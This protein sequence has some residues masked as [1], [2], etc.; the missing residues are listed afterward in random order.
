MNGS[1]CYNCYSTVYSSESSSDSSSND[2]SFNNDNSA[3][4]DFQ[5]FDP[6]MDN[7]SVPVS[8]FYLNYNVSLVS[9]NIVGHQTINRDIKR[10]NNIPQF[11]FKKNPIVSSEQINKALDSYFGAGDKPV[12]VKANPQSAFLASLNMPIYQGPVDFFGPINEQ[13]GQNF[14][15]NILKPW[16]LQNTVAVPIINNCVLESPG[17]NPSYKTRGSRFSFLD[18]KGIQYNV[19]DNP[20]TWDM[21]LNASK[22]PSVV[23]LDSRDVRRAR[24]VR[25]FNKPYRGFANIYPES[26]EETDGYELALPSSTLSNLDE[27]DMPE[28]FPVYSS[29]PLVFW[30]LA[31]RL[32][33]G[34][35]SQ[36]SL[37]RKPQLVLSTDVTIDGPRSIESPN[38]DRFAIRIPSNSIAVTLPIVKVF[39]KRDISNNLPIIIT[40]V[41]DIDLVIT[42][43]TPVTTSINFPKTYVLSYFQMFKLIGTHVLN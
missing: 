43:Y 15:E 4:A 33:D 10:L 42:G 24:I 38:I 34:A 21:F 16:L 41:S 23:S 9:S 30:H 1:D 17:F 28:L 13:D 11:P 8:V 26:D 5:L 20:P 39:W 36:F 37:A 6:I 3:V 19:Y 32:Q 25:E 7:G 2:D 40:M 27:Y 29:Y 18:V 31:K 12:F 35:Q 22:Y 14:L